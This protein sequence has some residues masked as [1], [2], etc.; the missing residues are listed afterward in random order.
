MCGNKKVSQ[1]NDIH[2]LTWCQQLGTNSFSGGGSLKILRGTGTK[3]L[4]LRGVTPRKRVGFGPFVYCLWTILLLFSFFSF[5][6]FIFISYFFFLP[7]ILGGD[8]PLTENL[9][10]TRPPP[11]LPPPVN[12]FRVMPYLIHGQFNKWTFRNLLNMFCIYIY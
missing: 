9:R 8:V 7:G 12:S 5:L 11:P 1:I 4:G 2:M 6:F 3:N 10:W